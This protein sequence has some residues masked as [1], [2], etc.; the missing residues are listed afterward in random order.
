MITMKVTP[1]QADA[2]VRKPPAGMRA[3][4]FYGPDTGLA[5]ERAAALVATVVDDP[6]DVFR[7]AEVTS[8]AL[9]SDPA[10]LVDEALARALGGGRRVI[11]VPDAGDSLTAIFAGLLD[12]PGLADPEAGLV[13]ARAG[14]LGGRSSLRKLFESASDAAAIA[15]Y[16]DDAEGLHH[17]VTSTLRSHGIVAN[18]DVIEF[19]AGS[20]GQDRE[21]NRRELDKL[22]LYA[23]REGA[24]GLEDAAACIGD[25]AATT[26]DDTVLAAADGDYIALERAL[27]RTWSEGLS[28][29]AVLRAAQR[30][31]QRLHLVNALAAQNSRPVDEAMKMLRPP[32]FWKMA[33]RFRG[34]ANRW[35]TQALEQALERLTE[36]EILVKSTGMPDRA[37]CGRALL[38]IAQTA[39]ALQRR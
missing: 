20:L 33:P 4:L 2:F 6:G 26:L 37:A 1:R 7:Y 24:I 34:Q 14:D 29:V 36:T 21:L 22:V 17:L 23:G 5:K 35:R 25:S 39:R 19:I 30:H 11:V 8:A 28:P 9:K 18:G 31:F 15:C 27:A 3:A 12:H 10:A 32:V 13:L 16:A 38:A